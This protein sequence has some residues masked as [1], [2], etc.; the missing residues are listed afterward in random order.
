MSPPLLDLSAAEFNADPY[1]VFAQLR[2]EGPLVRRRL[3]LSGRAWLTTTYAAAREVLRDH[4][5]FVMDPHN[6]G[7]KYLPGLSWWVPNLI[8]NFTRHMLNRDGEEHR[9]LRALVDQAFQRH[10]IERMRP[11][12][13]Q[14]ATEMLEQL[15][16]AA[17]TDRPIDLL[18][19]FARP[20]PLTVIC[21]LLGLPQEDRP[22]FSRWAQRA[23]SATAARRIILAAPTFLQLDRY[24][25]KQFRLCRRKPREGLLNALVE[26][27]A[28]GERLSENELVAMAFLLLVAGHETTVHLIT[29]TLITLLQQPQLRWAFQEDWQT[30]DTAI[31][32]SLRF[33]SP[34]LFAK[35]RY[36][37][38]AMEFCGQSLARGDLVVPCLAAA[39]R[40]PREFPAADEFRLDRHPNRHLALGLGVHHCL[41]TKLAK[42]EAA[43]GV[44]ALLDRFPQLELAGSAR[45]LRYAT[46][47]GIRG[48]A[49]LPVFLGVP[50]VTSPTP[51]TRRDCQQIPH[52]QSQ[53]D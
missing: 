16:A 23:L 21:E 4:Q 38:R 51:S 42:V 27:E 52:A 47:L 10:S 45:Q 3:P 8:H 18:T 20:Y 31:D 48:V 15:A 5:T 12:L 37:T 17:R 7:E 24:L 11:R 14:L 34:V 2:Q 28:A 9:R 33:H 41:G 6:A 26:A 32:E 25:R 22:R 29:A 43:T 53:V 49:S 30:S 40:D 19:E 44:R 35:G 50:R 13:E 36:A 1:R 39:N 46:K